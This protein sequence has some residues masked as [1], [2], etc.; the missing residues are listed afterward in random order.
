MDKKDEA[1]RKRTDKNRE[2]LI[3]QL[4]KTPIIQVA[5]QKIGIGR[6]TYYRWRAED[7]EFRKA[8]DEAI[9][10]GVSLISDMAESQLIAAIQG[11]S[12]AGIMFWLRHRHKGY[13]AKVE[14]QNAPVEESLSP[15]QEK[16][17]K[18]ALALMAQ[19]GKGDGNGDE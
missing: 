15:E 2:L 6:A 10:A 8:A 1:V 17:V 11:K 9:E 14:I 12:M 18:R 19:S 7:G 13:S 4:K 3:E 5:C 16:A